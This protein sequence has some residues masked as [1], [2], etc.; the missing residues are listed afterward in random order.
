MGDKFRS[1]Y[2]RRSPT[3]HSH[4]WPW[5]HRKISGFNR[6]DHASEPIEKFLD[7]IHWDHASEPIE[8]LLDLIHRDHASEPT[9][10]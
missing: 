6:Q 4:Q 8:K 3:S 7:L 9:T 2:P 1:S 10:G 5:I